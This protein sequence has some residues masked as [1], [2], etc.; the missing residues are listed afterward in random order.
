MHKKKRVIKNALLLSS[1]ACTFVAGPAAYALEALSE[2]ELGSVNG[3]DGVTFDIQHDTGIT[4][5]QI[6]WTMDK[7]TAGPALE[8]SLRIGKAGNASDGFSLRPI[9]V[10]GTAS[11]QPLDISIDIDAF[12][13][14]QG[15]PGLAIDSSWGRMRAQID[16]MSVSDDTRSFGTTAI[17]SAGRFALIGDGGLFNISGDS[18]ELIINVGNV[19]ASDPSPT[20]WTLA[21]PGQLY[22][23]IGG[24]GATEVLLDN[25]GFL[26]HM[27]EGTVGIDGTEGLLVQSKAGARTDLNLTF[28]ILATGSSAFSKAASTY[29]PMLYFGWRGGLEDFRFTLK[30]GGAWLADGTVTQGLTASLGFDLASDF[31]FILGEAGGDK[32]YL[33]FTDPTS[34]PKLLN[35][36]RK[37]VEF[38][39]ITLDAISAGQGVGG[40]CYGGSNS[41]GPLGGC[42]AE[43]FAS[44]PA[45]VIDIPASD[46]GLALISR[47]W[48]LHAYSSRVSYRDGTDSLLD[49]DEGW[50][51]IYTLGDINSNLYLYPQTGAGIT[52]DVVAAIQTIGTTPQQRWEN[53]THLMIG[54]TDQNLAIGLVGSDLLFAAEELDVEL[55]LFAGGLRFHTEQGARIQL[56]GMFGGGD[57]PNMNDPISAAYVDMNLEFDEFAFNLIPALDGSFVGFAGYFS[58]ADLNNGYSNQTGGAHGHDDGSYISLAEPDF[59]KLDVDFRLANITGDIEIPVLV[60]SSS[61]AEN[62]NGKIDLLSASAEADNKPKLTIAT[63]MNIGRTA[64]LSPSGAAS[65]PFLIN[66][67][68]F[69]GQKLGSIAI[70]TGQIYTSIT[71]KQQ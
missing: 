8:N 6:S 52:A 28:D 31:Q 15:R 62:F 30:P 43:S 1:A 45:Q 36:S 64:G 11:A 46:S 17:D 27:H 32:S 51:L 24:P 39:S 67:V 54:D 44:L 55:A 60:G 58:F 66:S 41:A 59:D 68:E 40:I 22:Y 48:G 9:G 37:D 29:L 65:E 33:E 70:P 13:N 14:S 10:D 19:D 34:L 3:R 25:L 5:D 50:A 42:A 7:G 53:G 21:D 56:R 16:S 12:T 4:A 63:K 57:I 23:R 26:L 69:G 47:N 35:P 61:S 20:N 49:I 18:A 71:L 2:S 38:G